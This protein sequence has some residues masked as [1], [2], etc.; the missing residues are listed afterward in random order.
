MQEI[1]IW[2]DGSS[3]DNGKPHCRS[4]WATCFSLNGKWFVHYGDNGPEANTNNR[5]EICGVLYALYA[6][7]SFGNIKA[8]IFSDSQYVIKSV[9]EWRFGWQ[10]NGSDYKNRDMFEPLFK[11]WDDASGRHQLNWVKGHAGNRGNEMADF[12]AGKAARRITPDKIAVE[13]GV[14]AQYVGWPEMQKI[15]NEVMNGRI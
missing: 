2:T 4:G 15:F 7:R 14:S 1:S 5:G 3:L 6:L 10:R 8:N 13:P 12:W 11:M 9:K